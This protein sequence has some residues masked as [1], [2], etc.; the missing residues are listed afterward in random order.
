[1]CAC[2]ARL[3]ATSRVVST[4]IPR[5]GF[6]LETTVNAEAEQLRQVPLQ[7]DGLMEMLIWSKKDTVD[8]LVTLGFWVKA[9]VVPVHCVCW[10][11]ADD[12]DTG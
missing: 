10:A 6:S 8:W 1:M 12:E 3:R 2:R 5:M 4:R 7:L 9:G 11:I